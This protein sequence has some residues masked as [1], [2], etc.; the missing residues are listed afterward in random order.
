MPAEPPT[1]GARDDV[2]VAGARGERVDEEASIAS[3]PDEV[4]AAALRA[5]ERR[6]R[7]AVLLDIVSDSVLD[8]ASSRGPRRVAFASAGAPLEVRMQ[9]GPL[10]GGQHVTLH[11]TTDVDGIQV[12]DVQ[13]P[14]GTADVERTGD[15][16]WLVGPL[17][18]GLV[19]LVLDRGG[20]R[21]RTSWLQV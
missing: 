6:D 1:A 4:R 8:S 12:T 9:V 18:P 15:R 21:Y 10:L 3:V 19:S 2:V 17:A 13:C 14:A 16:N 20:R 5:I 7:E 11:V